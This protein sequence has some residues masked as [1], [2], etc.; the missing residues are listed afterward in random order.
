[1][2][3]KAAQMSLIKRIERYNQ[4]SP[5]ILY[6]LKLN[7]LRESPFRF[8]RGT[9][10]LFAEDISRIHKLRSP[11]KVWTCGDAHF[12]N[13]GSY[14]ADNRQVYF[15]LNDFDEALLSTPVIEMSRFVTSIVVA[16]MQMGVS[17]VK[18]H[19][20]IHDIVSAYVDTVACR[21][22]LVLESEVAHGEFKKFFGQMSTLDRNAFIAKRTKKEKGLLKLKTDGVRY[23]PMEEEG[24]IALFNSLN[25]LIARSS[26]FFQVVFED[27][28]IRIA[29]TGSLGLERYCILFYSKKTGKQYLLDIKKARTSC[30]NGEIKVKQP[31]F[32]NEAE[33]IVR[34]QHIMQFNAPAFIAP[35]KIN[36]EWFVVKELQPSSDRMSLEGFDK[37]FNRLADVAIEM[38]R[39]IAFAQLR[40]CGNYGACTTDELLLFVEK[41]Q[42]QRDVIDISGTL[43]L[44]NARYY[45]SFCE[46]ASK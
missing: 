37:D 41:K 45:K 29:G 27:A 10:H 7:A 17:H 19:K 24:K 9:C 16:G 42:W 21:K 15:D 1:M 13:F 44:R 34:A 4:Y 2:Q 5:Q 3:L 12:E 38:A 22:A 46:R 36:K 8:Y 33:R 39:L 18:I 30:Y 32:K 11:L 6:D 20:S 14:K 28:A 35:L 40:S 43:A 26:R 25:P 31:R 23:M